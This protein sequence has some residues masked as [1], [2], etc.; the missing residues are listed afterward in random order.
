MF[1]YN[2][3]LQI[4]LLIIDSIPSLL[5]QLQRKAVEVTAYSKS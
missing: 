2:R 1:G 3:V 5:V 4:V